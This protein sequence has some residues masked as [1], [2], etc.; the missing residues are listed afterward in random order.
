M[1]NNGTINIFTT[2][3][4]PEM[5]VR[6]RD[7]GVITSVAGLL[8]CSKDEKLDLS[9]IVRL[10]EDNVLA[11]FDI[12][13]CE[14][15]DQF[16]GSILE[17]LTL[18]REL[19]AKHDLDIA[20]GVSSHIYSASELDSFDKS[21][22]VFGCTPDYNA[23]TGQKN[24]SPRS[25]DPG[26]RTA[27][28]HVHLG[29]PKGVAITRDVQMDAGVLCDYFLS[30]PSLFLDSDVRR[31]E[32]YGKAGAIRFKEYGIEYRSLSNFWIFKEALRKTIY[33]QVEKVMAELATDKVMELNSVLPVDQLQQII[34]TNDLRQAESYLS[35]FNIM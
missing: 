4:D 5:F 32:L 19:L 22:F 20:E 3:T 11:E 34:N 10:Q 9:P 29:F 14:N 27:G 2:G 25:S 17:G 23:M 13:P 15:F 21:A 18:T 16:N 7:N 28:G 26:L 6:R 30:L 24:P 31:K 12:N 35:R 33:D 1:I 8:G